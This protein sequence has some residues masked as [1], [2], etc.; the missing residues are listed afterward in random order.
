MHAQACGRAALAG[1]RWPSV[2]ADALGRRPAELEVAEHHRLVMPQAHDRVRGALGLV[3]RA[4]PVGAR[5]VVHEE[6][7]GALLGDQG[8]DAGQVAAGAG[9]RTPVAVAADQE[10]ALELFP[11]LANETL[12]LD[13]IRDGYVFSG[14]ET[15]QPLAPVWLLTSGE[16]MLRFPMRGREVP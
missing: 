12:V 6:R 9:E 16:R 14:S 2:D 15:T 8:V 1:L 11:D 13:G 7:V 3:A 5:K 4:H 10:A